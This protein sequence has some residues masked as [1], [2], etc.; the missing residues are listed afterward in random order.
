MDMG[1]RVV[2]LALCVVLFLLTGMV[3]ADGEVG[4]VDIT[5]PPEGV[6]IGEP[7]EILLGEEIEME[8]RGTF[9]TY[10]ID[11]DSIASVQVI[12]RTG[13]AEAAA[14]GTLTY[15]FNNDYIKIILSPEACG[16]LFR[17]PGSGSLQVSF[18][19]DCLDGDGMSS[20]R[21]A[22]T[23]NTLP[24]DVSAGTPQLSATVTCFDASDGEGFLLISTACK[25]GNRFDEEHWEQWDIRL[26]NEPQTLHSVCHDGCTAVMR[27]LGSFAAGDVLSLQALPSTFATTEEGSGPVTVT[28]PEK[29]AAPLRAEFLVED[30]LPSGLTWQLD[31][32]LP[33]PPSFRI[34]L[35][36][37][38]GRIVYRTSVETAASASGEG[39]Y[40]CDLADWDAAPLPPG[41]YTAVIAPVDETI[42]SYG[43]QWI[44][45][46]PV[47]KVPDIVPVFP[48]FSGAAEPSLETGPAVGE[49]GDTPAA[50]F[51]DDTRTEERPDGS[52]VITVE[53]PDGASTTV[54]SP[55]GQVVAAV[56]LSA[57][58]VS[59]AQHSGQVLPL[60]MPTVSL[61]GDEEAPVVCVSTGSPE[62]V[63]VEIPA[64]GAV[65]GTVAVLVQADGTEEVIRSSFAAENGVVVT[66]SDG[67]TVLLV[68]N[69]G[70]FSD[71]A[72]HWA[73]DAIAFVSAHEIFSG[74]GEDQFT[75]EGTMTRAMLLTVLARYDGIDVDGGAVWYEKGVSWAVERGISSGEDLEQPV[76]REQLA[77]MLYRYAASAGVDNDSR[78]SL[79][80]F[81]DA[82]RISAY[83][84]QAMA[85]AVETGLIGG[86][87][88]GELLPQSSATR[89]EAATILMRFCEIA[90]YT[91]S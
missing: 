12:S 55:D 48:D 47:E 20:Q 66:V 63:K 49:A 73:G 78:A 91:F 74:T 46:A 37:P 54:V 23:S 5:G 36:D 89:S 64:E 43:T 35:M 21:I 51:E 22:V 50:P 70:H 34:L 42:C 4:T 85:W 29:D 16:A 30:G 81:A 79:E 67:D 84:A 82:D 10:N 90:A 19:C 6:R 15:D 2:V 57:E 44:K 24:V 86:T 45:Q 83:A 26:N 62:P 71:V 9:Y 56:T 41:A 40:I 28:I 75:P 52:S 60:P 76:S 3:L 77:T 25:N 87:D 65:P 69:S 7:F 13:D 27:I 1:K 53:R 8:L 61:S 38:S 58:A 11:T 68:D 32:A 72:G 17:S 31:E 14:E 33:T 88:R 18:T 59:E 80:D 39:A